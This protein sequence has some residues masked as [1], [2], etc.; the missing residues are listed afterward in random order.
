MTREQLISLFFIALL[1][2]VIF[3]IFLI[4]APFFKAIFWAAI[5]AFGFYPLYA[6]LK[7]TLKTHEIVA[8]LLMTILIFLVVIPPVVLLIV[9]ITGQ[10]IDLYQLATN[11]VRTG[12]LEKLIDQVRSFSAIQTVE[13]R[14]VE[15][16]PLK[17]T[18]STWLLNT[19]RNFGD[20]VA[21]QV[22]VITKNVFFMILNIF[23]IAFF[24]FVFLKDGEKIYT[25]LYDIA[26]LEKENKK[27]IF[28]QMNETFGAVIRG[29][30]LTSLT[31]AALAGT[32]FTLLGLPV[33]LLFAGATFIAALVPVLGP[34]FIWLP[35]VIYL[36]VQH[37]Y[38]KAIIL[39]FFGALVISLIDNIMKPALIGEKTKLPYFLLF[40][41]ILGGIKLYGIMGIFLAPVVLSVFFALIKIYQEKYL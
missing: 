18:L 15:W 40:F 23:L 6:R 5:L 3:Q 20:F 32:I 14:M 37:Y 36:G 11:Y 21:G 27:S 30:L 12:E 16:E 22:G 34:I 31:Q 17:Q 39:F 7:N 33:P 29:Q 38:A 2:F 41:G 35:L 13:S 26:P 19:T 24:L 8:A 9:N 1:I 28:G 4:F 10:T 25:F